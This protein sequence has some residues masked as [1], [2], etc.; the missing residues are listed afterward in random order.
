MDFHDR[1]LMS[2]QKSMFFKHDL[3][4]MAS[5]NPPAAPQGRKQGDG[6]SRESC[7]GRGPNLK[8]VGWSR[9][10]VMF[11]ESLVFPI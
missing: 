6:P 1:Q 8:Q 9:G 5:P 2:I 4:E 7:D 3:S 10:M 11:L